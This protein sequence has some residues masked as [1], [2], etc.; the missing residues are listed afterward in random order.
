MNNKIQK[1]TIFFGRLMFDIKNYIDEKIDNDLPFEVAD[2]SYFKS[3]TI[4]IKEAYKI[5]EKYWDLISLE[6]KYN[7]Y[8]YVKVIEDFKGKKIL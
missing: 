2:T 4:T 5:L 7:F 8:K 3:I 1:D 6:N